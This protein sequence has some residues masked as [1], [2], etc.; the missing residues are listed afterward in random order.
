MSFD[1]QEEDL[2]TKFNDWY[3][4]DN[5][6]GLRN[7]FNDRVRRHKL[8]RHLEGRRYENALDIGCAE[9]DISRLAGRYAQYVTAIDVSDTVIDIARRETVEPNVTYFRSGFLEFSAD[10]EFDLI[11]CLEVLYYLPKDEHDAFLSKLAAIMS[12]NGVALISLVVSGASEHGE[13][14]EYDEAI[15]SLSRY[16]EIQEAT[17]FVPKGRQNRFF[18]ALGR[19][20]LG[21]VVG[22][23]NIARFDNRFLPPRTSAYQA[24]FSC[25]LK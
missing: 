23:K 25:V 4:N 20:L 11:L 6:W 8:V 5:P 19:R 24:L 9:G 10:G 14:F 13:Y 17:T 16:F 3:K 2:R 7:S 12:S 22:A 21:A 18:R 15:A 1:G